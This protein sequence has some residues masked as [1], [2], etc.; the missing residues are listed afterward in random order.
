MWTQSKRKLEKTKMRMVKAN[1]LRP[2]DVLEDNNRIVLIVEID[3]TI[4][5]VSMV[6][7]QQS[8]YSSAFLSGTRIT[9]TYTNKCWKQFTPHFQYLSRDWTCV[10]ENALD[11]ERE[12]ITLCSGA[13]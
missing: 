9:T 11:D 5:S 7:L 13:A 3:K 6:I 12:M 2:G 8:S 1:D 4:R 10:L